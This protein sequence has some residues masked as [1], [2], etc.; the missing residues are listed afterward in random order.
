MA[1][2]EEGLKQAIEKIKDIRASFW[3]DVRVTGQGE[4]LNMELEKAGR[5]ADFLEFG[6]L[7]ARD[8]LAREESCGGHFREEHQ[9]EDNESKRNDERFQH[10]AAW[11]YQGEDAVPNRHTEELV[12]ENVEVTTRSYK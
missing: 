11:E 7:L 2:T 1:R 9:T 12:F 10:V 4:Q 3:Q 5:V 6:E 8:A